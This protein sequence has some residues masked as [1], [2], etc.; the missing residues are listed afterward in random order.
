MV[1]SAQLWGNVFSSLM[2]HPFSQRFT[3]L[4]TDR[5]VCATPTPASLS[6][7]QTGMSVPLAASLADHGWHRHSCLCLFS[8]KA[9]SLADHGRHRHSCLCPLACLKLGVAQAFLPVPAGLSE[10]GGGTGIPACACTS[11]LRIDEPAII[12]LV[13]FYQAGFDRIVC[14]VEAFLLEFRVVPHDP[15]PGLVLPDLSERSAALIH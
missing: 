15:I 4:G 5:N 6:L 9:A 11:S 10:A 1:A 3:L 14:H 8:F 2:P 7:A 12:W 13:R